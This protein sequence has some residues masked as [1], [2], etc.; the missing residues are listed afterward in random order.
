MISLNQNRFN[1]PVP[2]NEQ[3]KSRGGDLNDQQNQLGTE[4]IARV[5]KLAVEK[6]LV[7]VAAGLAIGV[8][9]GLMLKRR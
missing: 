8:L 7:I 5:K 6:P 2:K 4:V 1:P 9:S 3:F